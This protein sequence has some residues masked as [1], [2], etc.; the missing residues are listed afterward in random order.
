MLKFGLTAQEHKIPLYEMPGALLIGLVCGVL[1]AFF[2]KLNTRLVKIRKR[3][4]K[5]NWQKV[6]EVAMFAALTAMTFF[7]LALSLNRCMPES[8]P[9]FLYYHSARCAED[10]YSPMAT[11]FFNTE[12]G[13][14]RSLLSKGVELTA[15]ETFSF[16]LAWYFLFITTYGV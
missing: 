9:E 5:Q 3:A 10:E 16:F 14:I 4:I 11:L 8:D 6:L 13:T 7:F 12:G 15:I 2:V 1:G